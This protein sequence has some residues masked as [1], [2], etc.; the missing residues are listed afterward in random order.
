MTLETTYEYQGCVEIF[1]V[2]LDV[3][4]IVLGRLPL[5][6]RVKVNARVVCLNG[7]E[8]RSESVLEA[9]SGRRSAIW[10]RE[11]DRAYHFGSI[12]SGG[13]SL[14]PSS[15]FSASSI[16]CRVVRGRGWRG[17]VDV[18]AASRGEAYSTGA[19]RSDVI[20]TRD[21]SQRQ[22]SRYISNATDSSKLYRV[23]QQFIPAHTLACP[24]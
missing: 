21:Q 18:G 14:S 1:V 7:L 9:T 3:V 24:P 16:S 22:H 2:F 4:R 17:T 10:V 12:R 19:Q 20:E 13:D 8:E 15:L 11:R 5:V 6:H 23:R